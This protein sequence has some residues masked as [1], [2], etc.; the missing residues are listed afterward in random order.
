[1]QRLTHRGVELAAKLR[2]RGIPVIESYPGAAQDI[3]GIPR[4]K[5]SVRHLAEG[6]R[7]FGYESLT[8]E[9]AVSHDELDAATSALVGQLML[10]GYWEALGT[11]EEDYL[12]VPTVAPAVSDSRRDIVLGL[13]GPIAAGKTTAGRFLERLGF[14]YCRFSEVLAEELEATGQEINRETLQSAGERAINSRFGQRRLQNKLAKRV[15]GAER[16]VVDG[17][18]HLEDWA[19][20]RERWGF[21][22]VHV[23]VDAPAALRGS[24]YA[25]QSGE[26][27]GAFRQ[28]SAHPV[29]QN[30]PRLRQ[31]ANYTVMNAG[32]VEELQIQ[33]SRVMAEWSACR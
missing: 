3:L 26:T 22:A 20:V 30:V 14:R 33:L 24:R 8:E 13:S 19:F 11:V 10:A 12:I 18:R 29:E 16:I 27:I 23:H 17:L 28:A 21:A 5:T 15:E 32:S 6:L 4:K 25:D 2:K 7:R 9:S 31:L 1:M